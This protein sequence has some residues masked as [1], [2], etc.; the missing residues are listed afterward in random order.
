MANTSLLFHFRPTLP[1]KTF[2]L[3][4]VGSHQSYFDHTA[5]QQQVDIKVQHTLLPWVEWLEAMERKF[6]D[7]FQVALC[8]GGIALEN[9]SHNHPELLKRLVALSR[10]GT[11]EWVSTPYYDSLSF[12]YGRGDFMRQVQMHREGIVQLGLESPTSFY[13]PGGI[14]GNPMAF[15][16]ERL[17]FR[18]MFTEPQAAWGERRDPHYLC[19]PAHMDLPRLVLR[20]AELSSRISAPDGFN[21]ADLASSLS[22]APGQLSHLTID[23]NQIPFGGKASLWQHL[24]HE[25]LANKGQRLVAPMELSNWGAEGGTLDATDFIS[26]QGPD[27]NLHPWRGNPM[28]EEAL[29]KLYWMEG[30]VQAWQNPQLIHTWSLLQQSSLFGYMGERHHA[31]SSPYRTPHEAYLHFMNILADFEIGQR[32]QVV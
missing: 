27:F 22:N 21:P 7:R 30:Q 23:L 1:L 31:F 12:L 4:E 10:I 32:E 6:S 25:Y 14:Y 5:F 11:V 8:I 3:F 24:I 20:H 13:H 29:E 28:Q 2:S 19:H 18:S 9:L 26:E 15:L 16:A 17:G